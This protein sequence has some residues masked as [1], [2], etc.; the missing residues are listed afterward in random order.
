MKKK[1][2]GHVYQFNQY[3][4]S[5]AEMTKQIML[6]AWRNFISLLLLF[7]VCFLSRSSEINTLRMYEYHAN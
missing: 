3:C 7:Y 5:W 4:T 6:M 1:A 2:T